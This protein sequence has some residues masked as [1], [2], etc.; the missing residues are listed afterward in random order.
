MTI[1]S[2]RHRF[3]TARYQNLK[4]T[5]SDSTEIGS[6]EEC[7]VLTDTENVLIDINS[8]TEEVEWRIFE[9]EESHVEATDI[10]EPPCLATAGNDILVEEY[11]GAA[12]I[13]AQGFNAYAQITETDEYREACRFFSEEANF[14]E[15]AWL[16]HAG[17]SMRMVDEY[18]KLPFVSISPLSTILLLTI[19]A[20]ERPPI[21]MLL[22]KRN[23]GT[24]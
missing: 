5:E 22:R 19:L 1:A 7:Q 15:F 9:E 6:D 2:K 4:A 18:C 3:M 12:E 21:I 17:L 8:L 24:N 10:E 14:A 16:N 23:E 11:P 20:G 13:K